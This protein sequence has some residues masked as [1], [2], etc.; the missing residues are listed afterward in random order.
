MS[1][2]ENIKKFFCRH[3]DDIFKKWCEN[4]KTRT[5]YNKSSQSDEYKS[6]SSKS[7]KSRKSRRKYY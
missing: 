2:I 3:F 5:I 1:I 4:N 6:K 7:R